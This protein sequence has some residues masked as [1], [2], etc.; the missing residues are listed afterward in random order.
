MG[1]E[2][3]DGFTKV[4][5]FFPHHRNPESKPSG[6]VPTACRTDPHRI[7]HIYRFKHSFCLYFRLKSKE[8][9]ACK[10]SQKKTKP[11]GSTTC[12]PWL[13]PQ[14][15]QCLLLVGVTCSP[16]TPPSSTTQPHKSSFFI[17]HTLFPF[18]Q[19]FFRHR[20][21]PANRFSVQHSPNSSTSSLLSVLFHLK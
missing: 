20:N 8:M 10:G 6:P 2:G 18:K 4:I 12:L 15:Q 21:S 14:T 7:V 3:D 1:R 16:P 5:Q 17:N 19:T 9:R 11:S 13:P